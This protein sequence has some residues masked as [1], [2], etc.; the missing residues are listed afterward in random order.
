MPPQMPKSTAKPPTLAPPLEDPAG[1]PGSASVPLGQTGAK[2]HAVALADPA[3]QKYPAGHSIASVE[4][5]A[6]KYP[7]GH[8]VAAL[9]LLQ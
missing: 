9:E 3:A 2:T 4:F 7:A 5:S 6:Q 1:R 8:D